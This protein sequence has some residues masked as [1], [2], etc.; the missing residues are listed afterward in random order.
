MATREESPVLGR[1]SRRGLLLVRLITTV[2]VGLFVWMAVRRMDMTGFRRALA[3]ASVTPVLLAAVFAFGMQV[4]RAGYWRSILWPFESVPLPTMLRYTLAASGASVVV[5]ARG[6]EALRVWWLH[7][8]HAIPL[9]AVGAAFALEKMSDVV[10]LTLV[11]APLPWLLPSEPWLGP[12]RLVTPLVLAGALALILLARGGRRRLRWLADLRL[13]DDLKHAGAA[14]SC[15]VASWLLDIVVIGLA[16]HAVA[17]PVRLDAALL[18]LLVVN[19]AIAIPA[20]PGNIG[21]LELA[22]TFA[23]TTRGVQQERAAA[24]ALLYHGVQ[25]VPLIVISSFTAALMSRGEA[26]AASRR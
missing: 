3:G 6:G 9:A 15:V 4:A 7:K 1:R 10:T 13:F 14:F 8:R 26:S 16:M 24:F 23:L 2:V 19:L 12:V 20:A 18:V 5:P 21:T 11:V 25:I 17:I 22:A